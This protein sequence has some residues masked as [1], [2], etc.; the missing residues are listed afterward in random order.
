MIDRPAAGKSLA[1]AAMVFAPLFFSTNLIF[2]TMT[3]P[4]VAPFTLAFVRWV[5]VALVLA[6]LMLRDRVAVREVLG[7]E[8]KLVFLLGFLGMWVCGALVYLALGMTTATNG[9]LI[10]TSSSVMIIVFEALFFGRHMNWREGVG[11]LLA[12]VGIAVIVLKGQ[13]AALLELEFNHGDLIFVACAVAWAFYSILYRSP[14]ISALPNMT[15]FATIAAAGAA[16][17]LPFALIEWIQ[18]AKMPVTAQSWQGIAGIVV[19]SSLLA[20]STFQLGVR[21]LGPSI[22][23]IFMYLM[24]PYGVLMAIT[25]LG[26]TLHAYHLVGIALVMGGVVLATFPAALVRR[27]LG[28]EGDQ[29]SRPST[30]N[31]SSSQ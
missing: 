27:W 3:V 5:L 9:T 31:V 23:G 17:L 25:V 29:P 30:G 1:I 15:L 20:F 18:G 22:A 14:R 16:M 7:K 2:G 19:F 4:H 13:L 21:A 8:A 6:P 28:G 24:P 12:F 11:S 10:Y 26:E